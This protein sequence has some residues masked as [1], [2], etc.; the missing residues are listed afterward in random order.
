MSKENKTTALESKMQNNII[1]EAKKFCNITNTVTAALETAEFMPPEKW[2][3]FDKTE[4]FKAIE[5]ELL[6]V[7]NKLQDAGIP[8]FFSV[9]RSSD[10]K[11]TETGSIAIP[12]GKK[13]PFTL[14]SFSLKNLINSNVAFNPVFLG[15]LGSIVTDMCPD[16]E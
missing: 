13:C 9:A 1:K 10:T 7:L 2:D 3:V 14:L 4:E 6:A 11:K 15:H 8:C 5:K 12:A 16:V